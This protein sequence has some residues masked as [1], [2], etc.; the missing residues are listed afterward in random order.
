MGVAVKRTV[1][2]NVYVALLLPHPALLL[3]Y[4]ALLLV[5]CCTPAWSYPA[6][7]LGGLTGSVADGRA[8][9][10]VDAHLA[11]DAKGLKVI[12]QVLDGADAD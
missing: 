11:L 3:A 10:T 1:E 6:L 7:L 8:A 4:P 2:C 5:L 12:E 9:L